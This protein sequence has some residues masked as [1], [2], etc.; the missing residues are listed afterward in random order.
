MV[1]DR[2]V[3]IGSVAGAQMFTLPLAP[4][5]NAAD[6]EQH[7]IVW[8]LQNAELLDAQIHC[9]AK[10]GAV[11]ADVKVAG[12]SALASAITPTAGNAVQATLATARA[13]R[14]I[15]TGQALTIHATTDGTGQLTNGRI[16]LTF[17]GYPAGT[18]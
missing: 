10:A 18:E 17:R 11:T 2:D 13:S 9:T 15:K 5:I 8:P 16:T 6:V 7:E 3:E 12:A 4:A 14:R 1:T